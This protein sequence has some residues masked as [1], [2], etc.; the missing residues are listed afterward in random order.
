MDRRQQKT[1][2]AIFNAL[3]RLLSEKKF[4]QITIQEL[5]DEAN[6]G[7]S[8]FYSHFE[9]KDEL[10]EALCSHVFDQL[11][12]IARKDVKKYGIKN[13]METLN[14]MFVSILKQISKPRRSI[15]HILSTEN[16][17]LFIGYF[18]EGVRDMIEEITS[19]NGDIRASRLPDDYIVDCLAINFVETM[20]WW[21]ASGQNESIQE[22][23]QYYNTIVKSILEN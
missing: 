15:I 23:S 17:Y 12:A 6:I 10:I 5:I 9:T 16:R 8:T 3:T 1:R 4:S 21:F 20:Q 18:K 22:L 11:L 19:K 7:R 14:V 2:E 13:S